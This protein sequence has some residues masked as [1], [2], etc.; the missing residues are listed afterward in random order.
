MQEICDNRI[1]DKSYMISLSLNKEIKEK[2][3]E[4]TSWMSINTPLKIRCLIINKGYT[5]DTFPKC[6]V[7]KLPVTYDKAYN[8][9]LS[10]YCGPHCS[11]KHKHRLNTDTY[12]KLNNKDLNDFERLLLIS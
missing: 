11:R 8:N 9:K 12:D 4:L 3:I 10:D 5:K 1:F 6:I 7:C 2:I